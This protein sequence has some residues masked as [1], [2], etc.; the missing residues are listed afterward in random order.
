MV[1]MKKALKGYVSCVKKGFSGNVEGIMTTR[2]RGL[3]CFIVLLMKDCEWVLAMCLYNGM[4]KTERLSFLEN[5]INIEYIK[6]KAFV[7]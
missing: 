5:M 1:W 6:A 3:K 7:C 2:R 4:E